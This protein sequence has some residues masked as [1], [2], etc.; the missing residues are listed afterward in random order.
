MDS[1]VHNN[2]IKEP[3]NNIINEPSNLPDLSICIDDTN[4]KIS[5]LKNIDRNIERCIIELLESFDNLTSKMVIVRDMQYI[6][7]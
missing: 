2:V 7:S 3:T 1:D 6:Q 5:L 4:N